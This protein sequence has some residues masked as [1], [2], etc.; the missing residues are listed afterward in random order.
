MPRDGTPSMSTTDT[1]SEPSVA[2]E[3]LARK[4]SSATKTVKVAN[5][6]IGG[7]AFSVIAGPC[8]IESQ[9]QFQETSSFVKSHGASLIRGG[10]WKM[11]T[12][13][14]S[15]Q[16]LGEQAFGF[17]STVL[18]NIGLGLVTE[19]TDPRQIEALDPF[20]SM[21]Q[22]GA[23]NMY[24][25]AL[26]SELGKSNKP[27]LLKRSFSALVDEWIQA[28]EYVARG[29]NESIVLCERG[30]RTFETST[31]FTLDLNAV[32]IAKARSPYPVIV[33]PSHAIGIR[34]HVPKLAL[35]SAAAGADGII[36]E[37]HPRPKEA[38][39]DGKQAL[40]FDDYEQMM[41]Q[42]RRVL[43][44]LDRP[45]AQAQGTIAEL[46]AHGTSPELLV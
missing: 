28:A 24:N 25:Y 37:V 19:V 15:F 14:K 29:G 16:G 23:R 38:L 32:L 27:I 9:A 20:V 43:D 26:L 12:N 18:R 31:R 1:F 36:V 13:A 21:Y 17:I 2:R 8:S 6:T 11:R 5:T 33:D 42:L 40:T 41:A 34:E 45:L 3:P 39:S 30:I 35:A 22:V 7:D 10:V 4:S 46:S 44:A